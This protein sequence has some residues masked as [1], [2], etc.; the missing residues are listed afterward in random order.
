[1]W[2]LIKELGSDLVIIAYGCF[3]TWVFVYILINGSMKIIE[4]NPMILWAEVTL[5]LFLTSFGLGKL[6]NDIKG[7]R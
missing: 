4:G 5:S 7:L 2:N 6:I 1:M 3:F